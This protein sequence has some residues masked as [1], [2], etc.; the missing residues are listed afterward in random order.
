MTKMSPLLERNEQFAATYTPGPAY[1]PP[2]TSTGGP[3]PEGGARRSH[4]RGC[5]LVL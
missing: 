3:I 2:K 1:R 5:R 4:S